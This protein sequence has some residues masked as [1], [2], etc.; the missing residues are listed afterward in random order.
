MH[1]FLSALLGGLCIGVATVGYLYNTGR[2]V[3]ISGMLSNSLIRPFASIS[4]LLFL[5][6]ILLIASVAHQSG[7]IQD[8]SIIF[9]VDKKWL[10]ISGILVGLGTS[11]GSGCTSGHGVCGISRLSIRSIV[12]TLTFIATGVLTVF[13]M[14][15]TGVL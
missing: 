11:L 12:A 1:P 6:G 8:E 14:R 7:L 2:V 5:F 15:T 4:A 9:L 13:I 3:G 10:I